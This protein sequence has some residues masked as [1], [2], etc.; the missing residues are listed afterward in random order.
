MPST[1]YAGRARFGLLPEPERNPASFLTSCII[2]ASILA[3]LILLGTV[4]HHEIEL[5]KMES[6]EIVFPTTP[7][8]EIK[9]KVKIPPAPKLPAPPTPQIVKLD[10]PKINLPKPEPKPEVKVL[11][12]KE[13]MAK[14]P[15]AAKPQIVLAPQPKAA[16]AQAAAPALTPQAH[17]S[18]E[19]VHLGDMNGA[20]PNPNATRPANIAALG[21]PYGGMQGIRQRN[22]VRL[23]RGRHGHSGLGGYSR[24]QRNCSRRWFWTTG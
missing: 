22:Q 9:V 5:R 20:K 19:P 23:Q 4:A 18:V 16:L 3:L 15:T 8:P 11:A 7:P 2:N 1:S 12:V 13:A 14:M 10:P 24:R 17:P 21:N 6:T